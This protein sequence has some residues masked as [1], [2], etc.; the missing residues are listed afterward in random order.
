M[1]TLLLLLS[2]S[3]LVFA[4]TAEKDSLARELFNV[5]G[6][7]DVLIKNFVRV[8]D[9]FKSR[10]PDL[11][12][13]YWTK[14]NKKVSPEK[15]VELII[16]VYI[17]HYTIAEMRLLVDFYNSDTG[18]LLREKQPVVDNEISVVGQTWGVSIANE[19]AEELRKELE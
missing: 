17:K 14:F 18:K 5:S 4:Q 9:I 11:P 6:Q 19:I 8:I 12:E 7:H 1:K 16:P 15:L 2:L 3:F 13:E 10:T